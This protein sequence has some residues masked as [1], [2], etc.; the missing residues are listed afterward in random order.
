MTHTIL[1]PGEGFVTPPKH[2]HFLAKKLPALSGTFADGALAYLEPGGGGPTEKH[3]HPH[4]HLFLVIEGEARV[5][6]GDRTVLVK[7]GETFRVSG[8]I[9]HSVWNNA[10]VTTVMLGL[11]TPP[12]NT[13]A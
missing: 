7:P 5:E 1:A 4:D 10:P 13:P 11:T 12:H 3:T 9:P 2:V 8:R 6:L